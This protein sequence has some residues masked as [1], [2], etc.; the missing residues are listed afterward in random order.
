MQLMKRNQFEVRLA[1]NQ[2][3]IRAAQNLRYRVFVQEFDAKTSE[4]NHK[5]LL[6]EDIFDEN[7]DHLLLIDRNA[8]SA[9]SEAKFCVVG[10]IRVMSASR[11]DKGTG[12]YTSSEYNLNQ[13]LKL[14]KSSI[15]IGRACVEKNYRG[16]VA[17]HLLWSGLGKYVVS[18]DIKTMFGVASFH[19][20]DM[21]K[22][23]SALSYLSYNFSAEKKLEFKAKFP[24]R[25]EM[26]I[27]PL[28]KLDV[29]RAMSEMPS[30]IRAYLRLGAKVGEGAFK[31]LDFNT[32]D[33]GIIID[34][35]FM[36]KKYKE[37]YGRPRRG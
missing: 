22:F 34:I 4:K 2:N 28:E 24:G 3:E 15:E 21:N 33:I 6:D 11:A 32:I 35:D 37:F 1:T 8:R 9:F 25:C 30:L 20:T 7:C 31:D 18:R 16:S 27:I 19:G 26:N 23:S 10:T 29:R 36:N 14:K 13:I 5:S 17:L 12:F